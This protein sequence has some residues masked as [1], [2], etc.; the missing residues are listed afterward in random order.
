S[1]PTRAEVIESYVTT[2]NALYNQQ[3][4]RAYVE[5]FGLNADLAMPVELRVSIWY[6]PTLESINMIV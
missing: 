2:I 4:L 1:F 3:A 6:N 5:D